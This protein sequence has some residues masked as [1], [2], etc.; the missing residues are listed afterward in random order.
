MELNTSVTVTIDG[1]VKNVTDVAKL[2][3][4]TDTV[5]PNFLLTSDYKENTNT[6]KEVIT[7]PD[8]IPFIPVLVVLFVVITMTTIK[9]VIHAI[10]MKTLMRTARDE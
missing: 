8:L 2:L 10:K 6:F 7:Y 9:Y 5:Q 4:L 3:N 1:E